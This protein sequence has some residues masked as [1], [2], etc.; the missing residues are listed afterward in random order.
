[1]IRFLGI[2]L[3]GLALAGLVA[4]C[5]VGT[6]DPAASRWQYVPDGA[7]A[8][9]GWE[10]AWIET[11]TYDLLSYREFMEPGAA[12]LSVYIEGDGLPWATRKKPCND[13]E[14]DVNGG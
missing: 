7:A 1:M 8:P 2:L 9:F 3:A 6:R 4:G 12:L 10:S 13:T 5:V 14:S 11:E